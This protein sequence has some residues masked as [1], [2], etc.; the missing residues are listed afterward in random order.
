[1]TL[2]LTAEQAFERYEAAFNQ[3]LL[4][5]GSWH[6]D[7][8]GRQL[9][10]A[11]GVLDENVNGPADCPASVMPRWL[12]RMVPWFFDRMEFGDA[13]QWGREFYA[14]LKRLNGDVP[15]TVVYDWQASVVT[16]LAIEISELR[17]RDPE[18]HRKLQALHLR[19]LAGDR[20]TREEWRAILKDAYAYAYAYADAYAYA[21]AYAYADAD[22]YAYAY[23]YADADAATR[24][25]RMKRIAF[26]MVE[27]LRRVP[28]PAAV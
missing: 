22:A 14:E 12:A 20:A 17:K 16:P 18:P 2:A 27:C 3:D 21:Y 4:I 24:R 1:M 23:A 13:R 5:Q 15:F 7:Q 9:A 11:L 28:T 25:E 6:L 10:C 8:D 26:G 19:A